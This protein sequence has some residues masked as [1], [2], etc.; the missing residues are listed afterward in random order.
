RTLTR[1]NGPVDIGA[2]ESQGP[3]VP[4]ALATV[5]N[6][7]AA[8]PSY[9]FTVQYADLIGPGQAINTASVIGTNA[10]VGVTGRGGYNVLATYVSIDN[11][12]N[13]TP[14]TATYSITPPGGA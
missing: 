3:Y 4:I 9:T 13:G 1:T 8:A 10:A 11:A 12:A 14:R 7:T 5:S 6:V 2:V